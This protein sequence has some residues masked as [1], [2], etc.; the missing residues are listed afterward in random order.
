MMMKMIIDI[1]INFINHGDWFV[2]SK[3]N[4][5]KRKTNSKKTLGKKKKKEKT[6]QQH[7]QKQQKNKIKP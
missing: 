7:Y 3:P 5:R 4:K 1:D 6:P 2:E